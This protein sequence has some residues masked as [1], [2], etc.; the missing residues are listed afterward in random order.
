M[1]QMNL[2]FGQI[3]TTCFRTERPAFFH[4]GECPVDDDVPIDLL[5]RQMVQTVQKDAFTIM[6]EG[7]PVMV[8]PKWVRDHVH[9]LKGYKHWEPDLKDY[10]TLIL[11]H[12]HPSG[13]FYE[14]VQVQEEAHTRV[15]EE[16]LVLRDRESGLAL[17]RLE[18]EAD[19]EYL[20][21]EGVVT[22]YKATGDLEWMRWALPRLEKGIAYCTSDPKRWDATRGLVK[23]PCTI[24]TWDFVDIPNA[25]YDRNIHADTPMC[26]M[27]G[28]N[29]G[30]YAA[31]RSLAWL[32]RELGEQETAAVWEKKAEQLCEALNRYCWNGRFYQ[33]RLLLDDP[34]NVGERERLSLSNPY[35]INRGITTLAQARRILAEYQ[36]RRN[37][38]DAFAEWFTVDPPYQRFFQY[39]AGEYINGAIASLTAGELAKAAFLNGEE[40]YGWDILC[41]LAGLLQR[42]RELFFMYDPKTGKNAGGGPSG[43]GAAAIISAIEEGLAG[44][45]DTG[46]CFDQMAFSPRWCVT[47]LREVKYITGYRASHTF[48]ETQYEQTASA[49]LFRVAAPAREMTCHILVPP[50]QT[51]CQ[52]RVNGCVCDFTHVTV[53]ES[54][55][56]DFDV[57]VL[58]PQPDRGRYTQNPVTDMEICFG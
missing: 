27:H 11:T 33:H 30:V 6:V 29:S 28:D 49:M 26:I 19:I 17:V 58:A 50:E 8:H 57:T 10:L 14:M 15:V 1:K 12:Q 24:D 45:Q 47:G 2:T 39:K 38:T 5:L 23:R 55:Y 13:Y 37:T 42:D 31:M 3:P 46:V 4:K 36:A 25:A 32:R 52:V 43:W 18:V 7:C 34:E 48:V 9:E 20:M 40:A 51:V 41:R 44:I 21:V 22:V 35:D 56:V 54:R 53:G 16:R